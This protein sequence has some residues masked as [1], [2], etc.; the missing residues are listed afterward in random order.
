MAVL[1]RTTRRIHF[2][3][4]TTSIFLRAF[5]NQLSKLNTCEFAPLSSLPS[6]FERRIYIPLPEAMAR[7]ELFKLNVKGTPHQLT[8]SDFM[9]LGRKTVHYSGADVSIVCRDALM[10]PVRKVQTATHFK[11]VSAGRA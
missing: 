8:E 7:T 5:R 9:E 11:R 10:M 1:V 4:L 6:S 2:Y 3:G